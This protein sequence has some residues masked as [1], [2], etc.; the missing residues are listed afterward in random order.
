M[1]LRDG[2]EF[3]QDCQVANYLDINRANWDE[4]ASVHAASADYDVQR[5]LRDPAALSDVVQFDQPRLGDLTGL[6]VVHLQCHIGTDTLS[7]KR[8]GAT[9]VTGVDISPKSLTEAR[10]LAADSGTTI[11]YV[12]ADVYSAPAALRGRQ[13]DLV[14][15]GIGALCWLPSIEQ[16][17]EVVSDLLRP[18]GRLFIREGHP[19]LWSLDESRPGLRIDYPYF[20]QAEPQVWEDGGT[21]VETD[22]T[23]TATTTMEWN[24]SIGE[25]LT[26][27]LQR[28]LRIDAF[29]EHDSVPWEA[30]PGQMTRDQRG[31]WRLADGPERL[32]ASYTLQATKL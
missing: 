8:L 12:E 21:Y 27:L 31:E 16:W 20:E 7:L 15:T 19:V 10:T 2:A 24:H 4:R 25:I 22:H 18:T 3:R 32:P 5:F 14:Y 13:F 17:A 11:E 1:R 28:G 26:A 30:L 23:F 6:D 9:S 29:V